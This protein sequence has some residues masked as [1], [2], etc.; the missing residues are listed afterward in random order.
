[1]EKF[2]IYNRRYLGSKT[3]LLNFIHQVVEENCNDIN[4]VFDVFGGT[5][6]VGYSFNKDKAIIIND[7][8]KTNHLAYNTFFSNEMINAVKVKDI[9][10][11][12]NSLY[13]NE[14][15]YYSFNFS[16]TYLSKDNM[17]KIGFIRDDIDCKFNNGKIN[18][19]EKSI[20]I[21]SLLYAIDKIANTVGHYDAYRMNGDLKQTIRLAFPN[22]EFDEY[23][24]NN[25]IYNANSNDIIKNQ[26]ADLVYIDT[27]YNSRQYCDAYHFLENVAQ[28]QKPEVFG[29]AKKMDRTKLKSKYCTAK[30]VDEFADLVNNI[31]A[32]Y[33]L[34]SY[35]NTGDKGNARSNAKISDSEIIDILSTRGEVRVFEKEY[36]LFTTGKTKVDDHKEKLY[37]CIIGEEKSGMYSDNKNFVKSPLNYTGGKYKLLPQLVEKFP[38]NID[39][40][41]DIFSGGANV[42]I[43][44]NSSKVYCIDSNKQLISLFNYLKIQKYYSLIKH[45]D[46]LIDDFGLSNTYMNGYEYYGCNSGNGVGQ[47][48]KN[49]FLELRKAYN[50]STPKRDDLFLLLLIYSFNNQIRF[51]NEGHFNLPVGKR[52]LNGSIRKKIRLFMDKLHSKEIIFENNDFRNLPI[53]VLSKE[54]TFLYLDPPYLLGTASYNENGGWTEKDEIEL[55]DFLNKCN[56][57]NIKFALS[58]VI[59]HKG[60]MH[61]ILLSW[62]LEH[63]FNINYVNCSYSNSSYHIKD[64]NSVS[65]E[66][67][68]T[69]Y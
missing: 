27:P 16:D 10:E 41:F 4:S 29:V 2:E 21:C 65:R 17:R 31:L 40:F 60:N 35:N 32:K 69:N 51:N 54:N 39:V 33:I 59:E 28:N 57:R 45:L 67:L 15:N 58:N 64:R 42:G 18:N 1:M 53:D 56:N 13:I 44:M 48:N 63:G 24:G 62:C 9:I 8:L 37:L 55:L 30:A 50:E 14:D 47:Y 19:R 25:T 52:D 38:K 34:V 68:I 7:L 6:I 22:L 23:N 5:G 49:K 12:Y 36:N 26:Y 11:E 46:N 43:N 20:L 61:K 3:K 66:V